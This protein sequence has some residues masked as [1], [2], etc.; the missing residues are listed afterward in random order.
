MEIGAWVGNSKTS[1]GSNPEAF[2][3]SAI[4]AQPLASGNFID[5]NLILARLPE[6]RAHPHPL[7]AALV[8]K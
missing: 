4:Y 5:S 7:P 3:F 1:W 2:L 8:L 6:L